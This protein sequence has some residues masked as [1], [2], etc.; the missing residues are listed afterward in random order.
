[1]RTPRYHPISLLLWVVAAAAVLVFAIAM[2][3]AP[4]A[5]E[6]A[7]LVT[8][9]FAVLL[10]S[11]LWVSG[12]TRQELQREHTAGEQLQSQFTA[13]AAT[14]GG[15]VYVVDLEGRFVYSSDASTE[16]IGY[17][18]A[19]LLGTH[20]TAL[21]SVEDLAHLA[22]RIDYESA[23][24]A[25]V[26][27]KA[28]HRDGADRWFEVTVAPVL[29]ADGKTTIG[30]TGTARVLTDARHPAIL[31]EIHRR[32]ISAVLQSEELVVAF[33]PI[34]AV[35]GGRVLGV[36]ALSRF[37]SRSDVTPDVVF[38]AAANA[39]LGLELELLAV[40]R[41]LSEARLLDPSLYVAVNVSPSV[42]ANPAL[43]DAVQASGIDP[44]R[45]VLEITEHASVNDYSRLDRPRQRLRELG[46]RLAID[47]AG[48]GYASLKHIVTLAPEI[49][50]IDRGLVTDIDSD[51]ARRALVMAVVVYA[52]EV[53]T[54][55]VVAEG[56][57]T[58]AELQTLTLLGVDAA[59][60]YLISRPTTVSEEWSQWSATGALL[61]VAA[62]PSSR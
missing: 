50:K 22:S 51:R 38:A 62:L 61:Y 6:R 35:D 16:F 18:P 60:G 53:G 44:T 26:V 54:T 41:A 29:A 58:A 45:V 31:R 36:E 11:H 8:G 4:V 17:Q 55:T 56:V 27:T 48:A 59:Q 52:T 23:S 37:P 21:L 30:R 57:E 19:E 47:D 42:L 12:R 39:G 25:V 5:T 3:Q 13:A 7:I 43:L 2:T 20:A 9:L 24:V 46:V 34:I 32:Q 40:R 10:I 1:M 15:W 33:Q 28:R 49:I 14:S